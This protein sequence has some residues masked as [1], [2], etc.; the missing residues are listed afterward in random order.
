MTRIEPDPVSGGDTAPGRLRVV[1]VV[2]SLAGSGGAEN[3][4]VD[5]I[6]ALTGR[7]DQ[8]L[9]RLYERDY[10]QR[11]LEAAGV[12][13]V[14]LGFT[15]SRAGRSWPL[16]ARR[17]RGLLR[18][19]RPDVV[20]TTLFSGNL[21]GQL[22]SRSLGI[23]V[24]SSFNRTGDLALQRAL[25]PGVA[26]WKG[27]AMQAVARRTGRRGDVHFR[28][29]SEYAR[30]TNCVLFRVP[31]DRVTVVP[32]GIEIDPVAPPAG[33]DTLGIP[34]DAPLFVNVARLVPEKGQAVL[35]EA[36]AA[37]RAA[38]PG[39]HLAIA[40]ASGPAEPDVRAMV[41]RLGLGGAVHL[42]GFRPDAR[43]LI[44]A[45]DVFVLS[46]LSEGSPGVVVEAMALGTPVAAF[47]IPPVTELTDAGRHARLVPA[48]S[49]EALADAMVAAL[50]SP[51][52]DA[53]AAGA[54][55]WA[56]RFDLATVARQLG[57]LLED[58]ARHRSARV[59]R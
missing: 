53:E 38:V 12:P 20:H 43:A 4:L 35:I 11:R 56:A 31:P 54:R 28:A 3:R 52:R 26:G 19:W 59:T 24:V 41:T 8:R 55:A 18:E 37:T 27:R 5:E 9:V 33:R 25:Q 48:R 58:R 45:A 49:A 30:Q 46:S 14:G 32:R 44:A 57:D 22:A 17:L 40:G 2:D 23:P 15:G 10:L 39:A 42:L 51:T 13:V 29:V 16:A 47:D 50:R 21:V 6:L 34:A 1:H 36:F 7:F